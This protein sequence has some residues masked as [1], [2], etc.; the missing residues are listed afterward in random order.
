MKA[1]EAAVIR[2]ETCMFLFQSVVL[3]MSFMCFFFFHGVKELYF[4]QLNLEYV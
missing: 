1:F 4:H 3:Y 2:V